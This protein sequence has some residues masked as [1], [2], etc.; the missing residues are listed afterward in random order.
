[1]RLSRKNRLRRAFVL[2]PWANV[3]IQQHNRQNRFP[4]GLPPAKARDAG[5]IQHRLRNSGHYRINMTG[6][7]PPAMSPCCNL[8]YLLQDRVQE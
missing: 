2:L 8:L 7:W 3:P 4:A 1:M 5:S 6:A